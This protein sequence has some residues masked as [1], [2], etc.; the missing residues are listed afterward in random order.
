MYQN[1]L[2]FGLPRVEVPH[3]RRVN[4][5]QGVYTVHPRPSFDALRW[6]YLQC[7]LRRF[8][9]QDFRASTEHSCIDFKTR[10]EAEG[11][12]NDFEPGEPP[13]ITFFRGSIGGF[14]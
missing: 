4:L 6:N 10:L 2:N 3:Q 7:V 12:N 5:L 1:P 13:Y 11:E 8:G 14:E 9:T